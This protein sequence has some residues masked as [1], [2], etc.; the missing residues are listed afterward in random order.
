[1]WFW[2]L[3]WGERNSAVSSYFSGNSK[4][5]VRWPAVQRCQCLIDKRHEKE[6]VKAGEW[7]TPNMTIQLGWPLRIMASSSASAIKLLGSI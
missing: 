6:V 2:C 3:H 4:D 7:D 5:S 1:M